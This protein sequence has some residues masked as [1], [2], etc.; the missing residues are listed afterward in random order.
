MPNI[1]FLGAG[2]GFA[3]PLASDVIQVPEIGGG[4]FR[5]VDTDPE[6]LKLS[7][8]VVCK[9]A[10]RV[11]GGRWTVRASTGRRAAL[12]GADYVINCIE[13]SGVDTVRFDND[14][15]LKYGV[16]QCIGDTIGPGGLFKALRT[17]PVWLDVLRDCEELCPNAWVLNYTNPM[18]IMCLAA[19]RASG[20][21][22]V[23]LCHSV[24]GSSRQLA[25]YA[26]VPYDELEWKCGGINHMS[27]FT[28]LRH[29]GQDLYPALCRKVQESKE[30]WE[31]DRVRFDVMLHFGAFVTESSGHF[32]E[33][34]PYYRK[35]PEL[36][37]RYCRAGYLG[38]AS[39]YA[40]NWPR[41]RREC[42][43]WRRR[44]LVGQ[45]ELKTQRTPEYA[46][47][48]I[49][50]RETNVPFVIH[51]NVANR[52]L[53]DNLPPDGCVEVACAIDRMDIHPRPFGPLP[54]Q[55]A[56]LCRAN[57]AVFDLAAR[58]AIERR[59]EPAVHALLLDPLSAAVCSPAEIRKMA[60]ELFAAECDYLPAFT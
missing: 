13:V 48:I 33:Y 32:S 26:G 38:G 29:N 55:L 20:T 49:A 40:D 54:P 39:F 5:L 56:A 7:H 31:K 10:D 15:P 41:W 50:A 42:D 37:A 16:S 44:V 59:R 25:D 17:V 12:S 53:I 14:I 35:R 18:S 23:G 34:I 46:S 36:I 58:A 47:Y 60:D 21:T 45:E 2:S 11:G 43:D 24:Q 52:G 30:L 19:Q 6:R 4:E 22:V 28:T 3:T 57:M 1:C 8:N 9:V 51:G 27:W